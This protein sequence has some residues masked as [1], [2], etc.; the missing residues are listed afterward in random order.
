MPTKNPGH[1]HP[2]F[3][4]SLVFHSRLECRNHTLVGEL[5]VSSLS[6][7]AN[8]ACVKSSPAPTTRQQSATLKTG[9]SIGSLS[10]GTRVADVVTDSSQ[11]AIRNTGNDYDLAIAGESFRIASLPGVFSHDRLDEG[12]A[13]LLANVRVHPDERVL[14]IGCG[15]GAIGLVAARQGAAL[16][17]AMTLLTPL[18]PA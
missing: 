6:V 11:G 14:D 9:Q 16:D 7:G 4:F 2:G 10:L 17:Q 1:D 3:A 15:W 18:L 12:T 13:F 5:T 8:T